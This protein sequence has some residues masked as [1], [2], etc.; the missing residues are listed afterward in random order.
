[1][2]FAVRRYPELFDLGLAVLAWMAYEGE[3]HTIGDKPIW[4]G[5]GAVLDTGEVISRR[6]ERAPPGYFLKPVPDEV[7]RTALHANPDIA[8]HRF[9]NSTVVQSLTKVDPESKPLLIASRSSLPPTPPSSSR[10]SG[11]H[12]PRPPSPNV[13]EDEESVAS[14]QILAGRSR[15]RAR[16]T[17]VE[18]PVASPSAATS[19]L[20]PRKQKPHA[21]VS[22]D[23]AANAPKRR[24]RP[25]GSRNNKIIPSMTEPGTSSSRK[26]IGRPPV[27]LTMTER[28]IR[29]CDRCRDRNMQC[30]PTPGSRSTYCIKCHRTH[31][32]CSGSIPTEHL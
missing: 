31:Q 16:E 9:S 11:L 24:G 26:R 22:S 13:G 19:K 7:I 3:H 29:A 17:S 18:S 21:E 2:C 8:S 15:K 12:R 30:G 5:F 27:I 25:P 20:R 28:H 14:V 10:L 4:Q 6:R 32:V 1:M 23:A